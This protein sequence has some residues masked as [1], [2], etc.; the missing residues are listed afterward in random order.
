MCYVMVIV[1]NYKD[2]NMAGF[3]STLSGLDLESE[4]KKVIDDKVNDFQTFSAYEITQAVRK[5]VGP[6]VEV[7]HNQV[8]QLVHQRM[9]I[10]GLY[11]EFDNDY[12]GVT[13][14][15]YRPLAA[16]GSKQKK[17]TQSTGLP[18]SVTGTLTV[19]KAAPGGKYVCDMTVK[20]EGRVTVPAV[21]LRQIGVKPYDD[22]WLTKNKDLLTI[23]TGAATGH[24]RYRTD[25]HGSVRLRSKYLQGCKKFKVEVNKSQ[26]GWGVVQLIGDRN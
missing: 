22:V 12:G 5:S 14:R 24:T 1:L 7:V 3:S 4:V 13:A 2:N 21:A 20:S 18:L 23:S 8:R 6:S 25:K 15:S 19:T 9:N 17:N 11:E 10:Q 16:V 26:H